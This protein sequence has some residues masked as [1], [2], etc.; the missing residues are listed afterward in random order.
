M[1]AEDISFHGI[2][3]I[4]IMPVISPPVLK[5]IYLGAKLAKS[6]AG[7][8]TFAAILTEIVATAMPKRESTA[9]KNLITEFYIKGYSSPEGGIGE[10]S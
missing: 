9:I 1:S 10:V 3:K 7:L 4:P 5:L 6:F 8:T 2:I